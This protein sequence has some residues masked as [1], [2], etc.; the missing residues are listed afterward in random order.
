[1]LESDFAMT[2]FDTTTT[3]SSAPAETTT[4]APTADKTQAKF[5]PETGGHYNLYESLGL[6]PETSPEKIDAALQLRLLD[7]PEDQHQTAPYQELL[8]ARKVLGTP[9]LKVQ[10]DEWLQ[11]EHRP[12]MWIA[13]IRALAA[14]PDPDARPSAAAVLYYLSFG[15]MGLAIANV[16][17]S[18][19]RFVLTVAALDQLAGMMGYLVSGGVSD[20]AWPI[21]SVVFYGTFAGSQLPFFLALYLGYRT[22][23]ATQTGKDPRFTPFILLLGVPTIAL[24]CV[25]Q[26]MMLRGAGLILALLLVVVILVACVHP[27]TRKWLSRS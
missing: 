3:A 14:Q 7:F 27:A 15:I 5:A 10:Y 25:V 11:D 22:Y 23:L 26:G 16:L 6:D 19:A 9:R 8:V 18:C 21:A 12:K 2:N 20:A 24:L 17:V 4:P 13:E 1:M